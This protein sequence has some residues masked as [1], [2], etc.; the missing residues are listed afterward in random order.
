[1]HIAQMITCGIVS[2]YLYQ[3]EYINS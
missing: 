3:L 1:M 2:E